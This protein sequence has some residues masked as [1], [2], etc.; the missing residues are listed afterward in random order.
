VH[1]GKGANRLSRMINGA[2]GDERVIAEGTADRRNE[3]RSEDHDRQTD[4]G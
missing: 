4:A 3:D 2:A 1:A